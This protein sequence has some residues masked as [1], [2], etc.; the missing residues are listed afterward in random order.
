MTAFVLINAAIERVA[1]SVSDVRFD[2]PYATSIQF[3]AVK[4][5]AS[6]PNP[7]IAI[8]NASSAAPNCVGIIT[9]ICF[10]LKSNR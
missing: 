8:A 2:I 4:R 6:F 5:K 1:W 10:K 3:I 7:V 9:C